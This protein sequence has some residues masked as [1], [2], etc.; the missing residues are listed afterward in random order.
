MSNFLT[1]IAGSGISVSSGQLTASGGGGGG[2][3]IG[4][5]FSPLFDG[6][7][8]DGAA[9]LQDIGEITSIKVGGVNFDGDAGIWLIGT[10][11][12]ILLQF[13]QGG[14]VSFMIQ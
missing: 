14:R 2:G 8:P 10:L 4:G 5:Y 3:G 7:N 12:T 13:G 1:A 9:P 6:A 11:G